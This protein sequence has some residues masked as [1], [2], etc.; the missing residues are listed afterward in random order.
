[1]HVKL[2]GTFGEDFHVTDQIFI[3]HF[4]FVHYLREREYTGTAHHPFLSLNEA[5]DSIRGGGG[6][7]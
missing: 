7:L 1:M 3:T 2:L 5:S 4:E 6:V